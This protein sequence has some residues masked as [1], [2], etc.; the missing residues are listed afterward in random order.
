MTM[1]LYFDTEFIE[2]GH[3]IDLLSIGV[4]LCQGDVQV[5]TLYLENSEA[6]LTRA[7]DWVKAN[8]LPHLQGNGVSR[9]VI[10]EAVREFAGSDPEWWAYYADYDWVVL[11]QLY[12]TMMDLPDGWPMH[13]RDLRQWLDDNGHGDVDQPDDAPHHALGDAQ[14]VAD[15]HR[16]YGR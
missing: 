2:D 5:G 7:S 15:T 3:T 8:V 1:R 9:S 10:A 16:K 6:D 11:C 4:V 13:C 14:W 12:G